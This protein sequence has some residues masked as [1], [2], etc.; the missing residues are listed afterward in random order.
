MFDSL[1][2]N[3]RFFMTPGLD[4]FIRQKVYLPD[5]IQADQERKYAVFSRVLTVYMR[6]HPR[7]TFADVQTALRKNNCYTWLIAEEPNPTLPG[8]P[9]RNM[10]TKEACPFNL[11]ISTKDRE[12][13]MKELKVR[14]CNEETNLERLKY[15]G[16]YLA[17]NH[18]Q[19]LAVAA[20]PEM[21]LTDLGAEYL[22]AKADK[23]AADQA[24]NAQNS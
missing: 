2:Y 17:I 6:C 22:L 3:K 16:V 21:R 19:A 7:E 11:F 14:A 12:E 13:A 20:H 4:A 10:H 18:S 23:T 9:P 8:F 1:N 24:A 15:T 5:L